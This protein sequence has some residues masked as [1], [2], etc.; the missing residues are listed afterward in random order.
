MLQ[1]FVAF[2]R[3]LI[4]ISF[5]KRGITKN[6]STIQ[7]GLFGRFQLFV[8]LHNLH[9]VHTYKLIL[10]SSDISNLLG[11]KTFAINCNEYRYRCV[12]RSVTL[13]PVN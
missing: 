9:I 8:H 7:H 10:L 12:F 3:V 13:F 2:D 6:L 11:M 1:L 5:R 4:I